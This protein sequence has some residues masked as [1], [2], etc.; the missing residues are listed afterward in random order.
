[1]FAREA[2]MIRP[3][4]DEDSEVIWTIINDGV[5]AYKDVIPADQGTEPYVSRKEMQV[6]I[7]DGVVFWGFENG[8]EL[9]GV[10]GIQG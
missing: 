9:V 7:S 10:M 8:A 1:M 2:M 6:E 4:N 5:Q 3:C